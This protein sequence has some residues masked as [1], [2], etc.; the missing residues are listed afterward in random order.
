MRVRVC[1]S[2]EQCDAEGDWC[3]PLSE[4]FPRG[5]LTLTTTVTHWQDSAKSAPL[6]SHI[7][8]LSLSVIVS[9]LLS[10][11]S[12]SP[13]FHC[14]PVCLALSDF[15]VD[16]T[17][18]PPCQTN[19]DWWF[20]C[21]KESSTSF[22]VCVVSDTEFKQLNQAIAASPIVFIIMLHRC[23]SAC[24]CSCACGVVFSFS[25][26]RYLSDVFSTPWGF[27]VVLFVYS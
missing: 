2:R 15:A 21:H 22:F 13:F 20:I 18:K 12:L 26:T 11:L 19:V 1:L 9:S 3:S 27:L 16:L 5:T 25:S 17:W 7:F 4:S 23:V 8:P 10:S 14:F 24:S 6:E